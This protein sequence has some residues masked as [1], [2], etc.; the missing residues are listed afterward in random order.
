MA[1]VLDTGPFAMLLMNSRRMSDGIREMIAAEVIISVPAIAF[2]EIGQKVRLGKWPD[3]GPFV[4]SLEDRAREDGFDILSLSSGLATKAALLDWDHRDPF[5]RMIA[6]TALQEGVP[7]VSSDRAF[8][9]VGVKRVW[10]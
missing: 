3:M 10:G 9:E 7:L 5:D 8:D 1:L 4:D 6:V 2:Y